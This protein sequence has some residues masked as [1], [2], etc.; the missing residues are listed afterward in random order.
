MAVPPQWNILNVQYTKT[1]RNSHHR[2]FII[3]FTE[4]APPQAQPLS[5]DNL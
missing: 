4:E 5:L 3:N 2:F 1:V